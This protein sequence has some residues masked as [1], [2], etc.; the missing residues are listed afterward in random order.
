ME[1][2]DI[3]FFDINNEMFE[4]VWKNFCGCLDLASCRFFLRPAVGLSVSAIFLPD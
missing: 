2:K 3:A 1:R 4:N